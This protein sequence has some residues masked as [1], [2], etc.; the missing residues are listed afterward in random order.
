VPTVS[1]LFAATV[2]YVNL[3]LSDAEG[4]DLSTATFHA[5]LL[6]AGRTPLEAD[7]TPAVYL[8]GAVRVLAGSPEF[9]WPA[10]P[11]SK[12]GIAV[13]PWCRVTDV[14]EVVVRRYD[15]IFLRR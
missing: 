5:A 11:E 1:T 10:V 9:P 15:P 3:P 13:Y 7:W 4:Q 8:D 6:P 2:E 12:E 14:P